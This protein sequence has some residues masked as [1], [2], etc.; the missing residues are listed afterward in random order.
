MDRQRKVELVQ[1]RDGKVFSVGNLSVETQYLSPNYKFSIGPCELS[2]TG[3]LLV[4]AINPKSGRGPS[5]DARWDGG[6]RG[7][8][9]KERMDLD[10]DVHG[11]SEGEVAKFRAGKDGYLGHKT[12]MLP[13]EYGHRYEVDIRMPAECVFTAVVTFNLTRGV[14]VV[15]TLHAQDSI[16]ATVIPGPGSTPST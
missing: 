3:L 11:V 13:S 6:S 10:I 16:S 7:V 15:E 8:G 2:P 5:F 14:E 1:K 12:K 9:K 4:F